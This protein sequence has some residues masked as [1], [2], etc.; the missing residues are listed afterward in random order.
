MF[1]I[2]VLIPTRQRTKLIEESVTTLLN[3]AHDSN[4][5]EL[6]IAIDDDDEESND[7]FLNGQWET[8]LSQWQVQHRVFTMERFGYLGLFK[9]VNFLAKNSSGSHIM[10]W[11]DD[12]KMITKGWDTE[13]E[14]NKD[15]FGLLRMPCINHIHPLALFPIVPIKWVELFGTVSKVNHSDWWIYQVCKPINRVKDIAV[16]V[17][18]DRF[19]ISGNNNDSVFNQNSYAL[20]GRNPNHPDDWS[21]PERIKDRKNWTERLM[22]HGYPHTP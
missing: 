8:F 12:A 6:L 3:N 16:E 5:I 7:Y 13:I 18:H 21:H 14:K 1:K 4:K 20:D 19:D 11:N 9:Y 17:Y 15:Y 22:L 2:S 10:F